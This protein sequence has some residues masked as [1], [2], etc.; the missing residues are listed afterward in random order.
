[1][2][3]FLSQKQLKMKYLRKS[4]IEKH[5]TKKIPNTLRESEDLNK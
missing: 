4:L 1:M 5:K 2:K 3:Q